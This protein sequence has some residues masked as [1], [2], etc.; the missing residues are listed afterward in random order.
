MSLKTK[1]SLAGSTL[2]FIIW[3]HYETSFSLSFGLSRLGVATTDNL[4]FYDMASALRSDALPA[5]NPLFRGKT[6]PFVFH[7]NVGASGLAPCPRTQPENLPVSSPQSPL[8][9]ELQTG[10]L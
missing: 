8:N 4:H 7:I 6:G 2:G 1:N 9:A 3:L 5:T 10:K